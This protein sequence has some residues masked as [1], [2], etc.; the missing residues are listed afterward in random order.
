LEN[1]EPLIE[2]Q[3]LTIETLREDP[4]AQRVLLT[5]NNIVKQ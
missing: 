3:A 5:V 1:N 2:I 4:E